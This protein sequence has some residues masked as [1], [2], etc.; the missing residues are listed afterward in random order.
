MVALAISTF[1]ASGNAGRKVFPEYCNFAQ[2]LY[3]TAWKKWKLSCLVR[4]AAL[5]HPEFRI[6]GL[7]LILPINTTTI[8]PVEPLDGLSHK[9]LQGWDKKGAQGESWQEKRY[10]TFFPFKKAM[11][12]MSDIFL[13]YTYSYNLGEN[14]F[15]EIHWIV[16]FSFFTAIHGVWNKFHD[17]CRISWCSCPEFPLLVK[18]IKN[19]QIL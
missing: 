4:C 5:L 17:M 10:F 3:S 12:G 15:L 16:S 19:Y 8:L 14:Y 7:L 1:P 18:K 2:S 6:Q 13:F 11:F 9:S